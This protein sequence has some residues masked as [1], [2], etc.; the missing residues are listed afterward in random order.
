VLGYFTTLFIAAPLALITGVL[1]SPAVASKLSSGRGPFNRQVSRTVH[2]T[3][4]LYFVA[5]FAAHV[6]MVMITGAVVNLNHITRG[7]NAHDWAGVWLAAIGIAIAVTLWLLA[8]RFTLRF[9]RVLQMTGRSLVGWM[10]AG[11]E[12]WRPSAEYSEKDFAD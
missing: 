4:L 12:R 8:T 2:F 11:M 10:M 3:V 1:Q 7:V 9:P 6:T 5:F